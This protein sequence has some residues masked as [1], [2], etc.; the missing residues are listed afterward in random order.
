MYDYYNPNPGGLI[1]GDCT[2]RALAIAL[3]VDWD[4]AYWMIVSRGG[5]VYNM[6]SSNAVWGDVLRQN[7][8]TFHPLLDRC[9]YCYTADDF[10]YDHPEG[11][12][13]LGFGTH[14]ATVI[15]GVIYDSWDSSDAVPEYYW[16]KEEK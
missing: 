15:D 12:C 11:I 7:G 5:E 8:F 1:V 13:V 10:C 6:P 4:T 2:V 3:G 14:V 9:P 16:Q